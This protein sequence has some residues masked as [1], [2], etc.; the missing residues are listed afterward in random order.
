MG[1]YGDGPLLLT[2]P[3][4]P[5]AHHDD[6][7]DSPGRVSVHNGRVLH[8]RSLWVVAALAVLWWTTAARGAPFDP[9]GDDWE[10]LSQFV[11]M[12]ES[13]L[14]SARVAAVAKLDLHQLEPADSLIIVHPTRSLAIEGLSSFMRAGGR[15]ILLD[16][17]GTGDELLGRFGVRRRPLPAHP[18]EMLRENPALAI[19]EPAA[20]HPIVRDVSRV[21]TNHATG[22]EHPGLSPLLVVRGDGE[23]DVL[24][25]VAGTVGRGH[26]I[27]VGDASIPMNSMLRY[28]GNRALALALIRYA[29]E[30]DSW[31]KRGGK[32]YVLANDFDTTGTFGDDSQVANAAS[33]VRRAMAGAVDTLHRDGMPPM[34]AYLAAV[35]VGFGV[36]VWAGTR[37]GKTH[38]L[39]TPRFVRPVPVVAHGG[40]A[41]HAAVLGAPGTSRALAI[42]ELKSALE[43]ELATRLRLERALP[44]DR[45]IERVRAERLLDDEGQLALS[46]LFANMARV[47]T[48]LAK[49][50]GAP[51]GVR[52]AE[53][54]AVADEVRNLRRLLG[55]PPIA[56]ATDRDILER[57]L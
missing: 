11:R 27:A 21:V 18:A 57:S 30:D 12:A 31:G 7:D 5:L 29:T 47:E 44:P 35:A 24:L 23:A 10:G 22:L 53:V 37:A 39:T 15:L 19:A 49:H 36:V 38:K 50:P 8:L 33:E 28:P 26:M 16:D 46:R 55:L 13:E 52:D 34:A 42:L 4:H 1:F 2:S 45:L 51:M 43:E 41:G 14:G 25:A 56:A 48:R 32:L 9:H 54:I 40:I 6:S 17:Y 3:P 20:E